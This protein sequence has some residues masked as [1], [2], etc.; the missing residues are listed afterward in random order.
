MCK[1]AQS[2]QKGGEKM[3]YAK[4]RGAI[5]EKFGTQ[6]AFAQ[7]LGIHSATLNAKLSDRTDWTRREIERAC[8]LL[9]VPL[10]EMCAY[11]FAS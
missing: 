4:L 1:D 2:R 10:E 8:A 5:R 11:F 6:E 7:A 3:K 9:E